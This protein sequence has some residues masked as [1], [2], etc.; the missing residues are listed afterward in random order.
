MTSEFEGFPNVL[1]EAM[2]HGCPVISFD[3]NAGPRDIIHH[4]IDGLLVCPE[5]INGLTEAMRKLMNDDNLRYQ[6]ANRAIEVKNKFSLAKIA[7]F[8]EKLFDEKNL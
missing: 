6:L 1:V 8:W 3:C 7:Y 4:E 5:K 2:S